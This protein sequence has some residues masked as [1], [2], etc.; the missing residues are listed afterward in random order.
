[1]SS[2]EL[3]V[4]LKL[5]NVNYYT[6]RERGFYIVRII[7]EFYNRGLFHFNMNNSYFINYEMCY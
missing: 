4:I 2:V 5:H 6:Q 7:I 3:W 1:M